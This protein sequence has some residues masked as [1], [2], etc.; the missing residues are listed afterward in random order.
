MEEFLA[1]TFVNGP[2]EAVF[3]DDQPAKLRFFMGYADEYSREDGA[4][5]V[6]CDTLRLK[7]APRSD[8]G[9]N[10]YLAFFDHA[11]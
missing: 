8:K 11:R 5:Q 10:L 9:W 4:E 3:R 6:S 2:E 7:N 1:M